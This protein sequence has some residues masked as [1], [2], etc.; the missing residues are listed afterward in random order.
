MALFDIFAK[1]KTV[2]ILKVKAAKEGSI[3]GFT[4][5]TTINN[6]TKA[7]A[8]KQAEIQFSSGLIKVPVSVLKEKYVEKKGLPTTTDFEQKNVIYCDF[9]GVVDDYELSLNMPFDNNEDDSFRI[10]KLACPHKIYK[11][12]KLAIETNS[13]IVITSMWRIYGIEFDLIIHRCLKNCGIK[14]YVDYYNENEDLIMD[15]SSV[16]PT[17]NSG[18]R[19]DEIRNHIMH[20]SYTNFV[21]FEDEHEIDLDLNPIMT[22]TRIGL[23]DE[24][25]ERAYK[26]LSEV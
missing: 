24:H 5:I 19:T 9:N 6:S 1:G 11:L 14:E 2:K 22:E 8:L 16:C 7:A 18:K 21:V 23:L 20:F 4:Y 12:T 3:A 17:E 26:V 15:L 13:E 10:A 25:I